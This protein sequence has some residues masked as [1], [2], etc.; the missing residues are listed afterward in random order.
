MTRGYEVCERFH[1]P[2]TIA[3]GERT[4]FL[5]RGFKF[6]WI[7]WAMSGIVRYYP[8]GQILFSL[9]ASH[10]LDSPIAKFVLSKKKAF[11]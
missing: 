5:E 11:T 3:K 9:Y 6:M 2:T 7:T 8:I 10:N 1:T 4:S